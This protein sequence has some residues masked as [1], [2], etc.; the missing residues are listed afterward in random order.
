MTSIVS[1]VVHPSRIFRE[2]LT[3]ILAKS[4]FEPACSA[5]STKDVPSTISGAGEQ[6]LVLIGVREAS[7]LAEALRATKATFPDA[8]V[9]SSGMRHTRQCDDRP[10]VGRDQLY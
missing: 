10:R 5:S 3:S 1:V 6:V 2:G 4:P 9:W 8:H 7:N